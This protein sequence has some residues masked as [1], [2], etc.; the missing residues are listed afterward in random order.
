M[1]L[2]E[3]KCMTCGELG[4]DLRAIKLRD[5]LTNCGKCGHAAE[6]IVSTFNTVGNATTK[7][8]DARQNSETNLGG[9]NIVD[10]TFQDAPT[11]ISIPPGTRLKI[12][13]TEFKNVSKPVEVNARRSGK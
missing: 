1:P 4:Q 10:C 12:R 7:L 8:P 9:T 11:G 6:R 2:Y 5:D 13:G 3:Y